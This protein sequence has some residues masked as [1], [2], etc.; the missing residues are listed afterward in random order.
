[1]LKTL[2]GKKSDERFPA[3]SFVIAEGER[4]GRPAFAM[5]NKAYKNY[6]FKSEYPWHIEIE[7]T[8]REVSEAGLPLNTEA[9]VLNGLEDLIEAEMKKVCTVHYIARQSW[10]SLRMIDY[11][12]DDGDAAE[13]VLS[14]VSRNAP[15]R[16]LTFKVER[17]DTWEICEGFF[18]NM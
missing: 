2:F 12:V 9:N 6:A 18:H 8:M 1:M 4:E 11:Y 17:D 15:A 13:R 3:E 10:N 5:I 7:V 14:G 16:D